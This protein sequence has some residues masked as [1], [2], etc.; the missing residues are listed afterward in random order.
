MNKTETWSYSQTNSTEEEFDTSSEEN[1]N[2]AT[3]ISKRSTI[4]GRHMKVAEQPNLIWKSSI[5]RLKLNQMDDHP[6][7]NSNLA[8]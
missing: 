8:A 7:N 4:P 2:A 1:S 6:W 3:P 5:R